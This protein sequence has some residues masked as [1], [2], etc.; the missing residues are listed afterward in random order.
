MKCANP[1]EKKALDRI[2]TMCPGEAAQL[3]DIR[4]QI[5]QNE[6]LGEPA[7][8]KTPRWEG[9]A[10]HT[11]IGQRALAPEEVKLINDTYLKLLEEREERK[12]KRA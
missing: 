3:R 10:P 12:R 2:A 4:T 8:Y 6:A 11:S 7:P 9:K 1:G 5:N